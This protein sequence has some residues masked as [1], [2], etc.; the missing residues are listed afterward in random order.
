[1][2]LP[3]IHSQKKRFGKFYIFE[4]I[5]DNQIEEF[6]LIFVDLRD[7]QPELFDALYAEC[8]GNPALKKSGAELNLRYESNDPEAV[9]IFRKMVIADLTGMQQTLDI[10]GIKHDKFDFESELGWE[11]SNDRVLNI[12]KASPYFSPPTQS[13]AKGV[14][15]G[16]Y[17]D[18]DQFIKD[19]KLPQGK[20]GYQPDYP[21]L[22][23][24]RPDGSTLYTFR[25]VVYSLKKGSLLC[26]LFLL[27]ASCQG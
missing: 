8:K 24:L 20:K 23:V 19:K 27:I 13:N 15:E 3:S 6:F 5:N 7:R 9:K 26:K 17:F 10:F 21:P 22:Y 11:G 4:K 1:M 12:M 2:L 14:P 25:D 16:G 18:L